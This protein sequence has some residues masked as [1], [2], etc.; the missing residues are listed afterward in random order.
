M[1]TSSRN[2]YTT[3]FNL[4]DK[5]WDALKQRF[6]NKQSLWTA[7]VQSATSYFNTKEDYQKVQALYKKHQGEFGEA[8]SSANE[9]F[10]KIDTESN[11]VEKNVPEI[12]RWLNNTLSQASLIDEDNREFWKTALACPSRNTPA[13]S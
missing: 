3:L 10:E 7:L 11:W 13:A 5:Q 1:L 4:L 9:V 6:E 2:G 8:E 12:D